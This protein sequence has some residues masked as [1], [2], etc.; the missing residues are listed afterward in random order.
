MHTMRLW[1]TTTDYLADATPT[2]TTTD[3]TPTPPTP[4]PQ[5]RLPQY[6]DDASE[7]NNRRRLQNLP[8]LPNLPLRRSLR[9]TTSC[10]ASTAPP[11]FT[12]VPRP[13]T[14]SH[15]VARLRPSALDGELLNTGAST[16]DDCSPDFVLP[17]PTPRRHLMLTPPLRDDVSA[18]NNRRR[19]PLFLRTWSSAPASPTTHDDAQL[20]SQRDDD[21]ATTLLV[22]PRPTTQYD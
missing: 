17:T 15:V 22:T 1:L 6:H 2:T 4:D 18:L 16:L 7:G 3:A 19:P 14:K 21:D 11:W 5:R 9:R 8:N 20:G 12:A 13:S 10:R